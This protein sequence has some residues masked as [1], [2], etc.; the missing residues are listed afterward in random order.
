MIQVFFVTCESW[1][2]HFLQ[3]YKIILALWYLL[4]EMGLFTTRHIIIDLKKSFPFPQPDC[5]EGNEMVFCDA[6]NIC[7][8]QAC[9]GI[10]AIPE[11]SWICR[12]C[13]A[14]VK[15]VCV[16]CP[17][18]GGAMKN[19]RSSSNLELIY[20]WPLSNCKTSRLQ[21]LWFCFYSI[22]M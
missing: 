3:Y 15:P 2:Y 22:F 4:F 7:V 1:M 17:N 20:C 5:E 10:T 11:G 19:T 12:P 6:C 21:F 8:H 13:A 9:Y 14:N 18:L 16:L